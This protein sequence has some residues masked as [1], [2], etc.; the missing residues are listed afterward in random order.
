[1]RGNSGRRE[2][3]VERMVLGALV[4]RPTLSEA[5]G[6]ESG[7][8]HSQVWVGGLGESGFLQGVGALEPS[9]VFP[10]TPCLQLVHPSQVQA[11]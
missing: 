2:G 5:L 10:G 1:M 7:H 11:S 8:E 9:R 6:V 4:S 3:G